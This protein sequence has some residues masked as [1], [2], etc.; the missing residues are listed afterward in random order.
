[1]SVAFVNRLHIDIKVK[2]RAFRSKIAIRPIN[3]SIGVFS[4][5]WWHW[6]N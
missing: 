3:F 2:K 6:L 1:M 5:V 4:L